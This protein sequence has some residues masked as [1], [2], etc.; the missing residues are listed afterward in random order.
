MLAEMTASEFDQWHERITSRPWYLDPT[1]YYG[2]H[3]L[4]MFHNMHSKDA[5]TPEQVDIYYREPP[6]EAVDW[7]KLKAAMS[8]VS[9]VVRKD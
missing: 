2:N 4:A 3:Q 6:K 8:G 1:R 7:R 5:V 9:G